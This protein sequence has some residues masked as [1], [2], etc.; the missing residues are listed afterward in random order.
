VRAGDV[1]RAGQPVC[2]LDDRDLALERKKWDTERRQLIKQF[3]EAMARHD[4][5]QMQITLA[6]I[7]Q[8]EAQ[9]N[10]M[11]EQL[12][13]T[14][15]TAPFDAVVI[16][17]DLSQALGAPV[18]RGQVL[19]ELA[20]LNAY[21]AIVEIDERDIGA[22]RPGQAG[23]MHFASIPGGFPIS[24]QKLTPVTVSKEGR[25]YFRVEAGIEKGSGRLRPGMD[26]VAKITVDRRRLIW[27]WTHKAVDL[28][29]LKTWRW[30]P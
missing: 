11:D 12:R 13:R 5:S 15:I 2:Q 25:N 23:E 26:G 22:V 28:V 29:R 30:M 16:S 21:R 1:V 17:G 24:V 7:G 3:D 20:P 18:E 8:T 6:K 4:R 14:R 9:I 19:F 10:L 27:V